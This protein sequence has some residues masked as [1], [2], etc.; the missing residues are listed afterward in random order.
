MVPSLS[1]KFTSTQRRDDTL[2]QTNRVS[3]FFIDSSHQHLLLSPQTS[4][5]HLFPNCFKSSV[6]VPLCLPDN[7]T[8]FTESCLSPITFCAEVSPSL[9]LSLT[10]TLLLGQQVEP[11]SGMIKNK[12]G[13]ALVHGARTLHL[14]LQE[15]YRIGT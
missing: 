8:Y 10:H 6:L 1:N 7:F 4:C 13:S 15:R 14:S 2:A 3:L 5:L 11:V 9:P 12:Q